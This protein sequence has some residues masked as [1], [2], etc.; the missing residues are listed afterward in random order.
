MTGGDQKVGHNTGQ[1]GGR[2]LE[3]GA[4]AGFPGPPQVGT[5]VQQALQ[6]L[7][8]GFSVED[9]VCQVPGT[10]SSMGVQ[11]LDTQ[12]PEKTER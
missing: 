10:G 7:R 11:L 9:A 4:Q 5:G 1:V 12:D 3:V 2:L 8:P 6:G